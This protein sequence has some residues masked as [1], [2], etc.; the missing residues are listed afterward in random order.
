MCPHRPLELDGLH[1]S[2]IDWNEVW[3]AA[4]AGATRRGDSES[5]DR[6]APSFARHAG[7]SEYADRMMAIL[8]PDPEWSALDVGCGPGTLTL[9]LARRVQSVTALDFSPRML[10]LLRARCSSRGVRNVVP[11]LGAWE[12]DW[13]MLGLGKFDLAIASRS[14]S[15]SDLRAAVE[16]LDGIATRRAVVAASVGDGPVDRRVFEAVG[17][18]FVPGPDYRYVHNM[19]RQLGIEARLDF[20]P[21]PDDRKYVTVGE[22]VEALAW[23]LVEPAPEELVRLREWLERALVAHPEG[24][25]FAEPRATEW[26]VL[27]WNTGAR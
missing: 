17:R 26:A 24:L 25:R 10:D 6:R 16:K 11:V 19:L 2:E 21:V 8:D 4:R 9:P 5:W 12:D 1:G 27:S 13:S 15:V 22:A 7:R 14:L 20:I 18:P 23:M 3:Q